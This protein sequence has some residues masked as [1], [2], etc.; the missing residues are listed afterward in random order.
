MNRKRFLLIT[1]TVILSLM[2]VHVRTGIR[3]LNF[4]FEALVALVIWFALVE[5]ST[6]YYRKYWLSEAFTYTHLALILLGASFIGF[7]FPEIGP[8][9]TPI[10]IPVALI[11]L[12]FFSPEIAITTGFLMSLFALYRWSY[13]IFLLLPF[14]STTFVASVTLSKANRR[15]DVVKSSA[16]TSLVLMG[17]SLFMKFGL[18]IEYTPYDLLAAIL[19]PIFSGILVLGILP[20]VEYTSRLYSNLGLMEFGNLNH[21]LLKMLS[22]KAPGT[23]YHSVIVS[24]LA[25]TAAEKIGANPILARIGAYY[26]DIGK[27]K[28]P[29]FF[30]ENIRDGKNPHEDITP[31]LSHLVLNEHV[32]YGVELARKYRLPLL[33]EFIIPQHHGTRSQKYF[34]YKAKQQFEDIPEEEFR[35]PG[36]KPQ[37]RE[38][39]IIMLADS[40]EAASR[41]LKSPS[42]SQIKE[43]V[44]DV[45]S[46]IFFERQLDESGI[47]LSELEKISDAFLQ[48]LVNLFSSRIE[49]PEEEKIQ[50]VVKIND[51]NTG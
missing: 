17:T 45:I 35:Y 46:S 26:H 11:E 43:C 44:E 49:Y 50:K 10:Y 30:T 29:H 42:V 19:N 33:V 32:K 7:S 8:F 15:L 12:V 18:K 40:V 39:A 25:E 20:Y 48:V 9:V 21:P 4:I 41:S 13:D 28:R 22:I 6:R 1:I 37:F 3:P 27:M 38:A 36:P 23:Y 51:K 24:N 14:I 16:L 34:Y 31:S 2:L 5:M 47:T